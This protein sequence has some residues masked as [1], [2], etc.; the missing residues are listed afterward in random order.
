MKRYAW[1]ATAFIVVAATLWLFVVTRGEGGF[2]RFFIRSGV[3]A[4]DMADG[5]RC[6]INRDGG[7]MSCP[8]SCNT[9]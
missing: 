1:Y 9:R 7:A 6:Y 3:Y 5:Q 8:A 2:T 4:V